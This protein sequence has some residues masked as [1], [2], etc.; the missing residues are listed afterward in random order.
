MARIGPDDLT[1]LVGA[2]L[3]ALRVARGIT[4][5]EL[6]KLAGCSHLTI[7]AVERGDDSPTLST[8]LRIA[9]A[10]GLRSCELLLVDTD[11][12]STGIREAMRTKPELVG[13]ARRWL[14]VMVN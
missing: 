13:V 7:A 12:P 2:R 1:L 3:T 11:D 8:I 14:K 5:H 6:S 9:E 10:L 4:R